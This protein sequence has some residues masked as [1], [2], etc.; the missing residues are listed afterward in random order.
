MIRSAAVLALLGAAC[1]TEVVE[2]ILDRQAPPIDANGGEARRD[3]RGRDAADVT[4]PPDTQP[5]C[6][7]RYNLCRDTPQ[8]QSLIGPTSVCQ[9]GLCTGGKGSCTVPTDCGSP[10]TEWLCTTA[11]DTLA[12]CP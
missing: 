11:P 4:R 10:A 2:L 1:Q 7:C 12:S 8:C 3:A 9:T 5:Q 6:V